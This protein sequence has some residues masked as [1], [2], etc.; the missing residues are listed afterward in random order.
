[1]SWTQ[2]LGQ[3]KTRFCLLEGLNVWEV[4]KKE[5]IYTS[6][7]PIKS[8]IHIGVWPFPTILN[9]FVVLPL[10]AINCKI[11]VCCILV[12]VLD[13]KHLV[14]YCKFS[15][16][17]MSRLLHGSTNWG[18][19]GEKDLSHLNPELK[20]SKPCMCQCSQQCKEKWFWFVVLLF[21]KYKLI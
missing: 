11:F 2:Y 13:H 14:F 4:W 16:E 7:L 17:A 6:S 3:Y 21:S 15:N 20:Q 8:T 10:F 12:R 19:W 9:Y 1:M 18:C 5:C